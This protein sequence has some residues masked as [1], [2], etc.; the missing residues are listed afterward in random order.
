MGNHSGTGGSEN[1]KPLV[2]ESLRLGLVL[3]PPKVAISEGQ[4]WVAKG[5]NLYIPF[6]EVNGIGDKNILA[7]EKLKMSGETSLSRF[8][9]PKT[10]KEVFK[11]KTA[12][13]KGALGKLL[14]GI[15]A[16]DV[17]SFPEGIEKHL[18]NGR[19]KGYFVSIP[20]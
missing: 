9:R 15:G 3:V 12:R 20:S 1:K 6:K 16:Y 2:K 4:R 5:N 14:E 11:P 18:F 19:R 8:L 7:I 10:N 13:A 17:D